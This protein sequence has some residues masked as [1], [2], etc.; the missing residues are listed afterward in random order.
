[1]V[2]G[3]L[4]LKDGVSL[5]YEQASKV[6]VTVT[7]TDSASHQITKTFSISVG[8]VNEAQTAMTLS[9]SKVTEN[10][11]GAVI[12]TLKVTDPDAGDKQSF[13]VSD[14]ALR[15]G[16]QQAPAEGRASRSTTSRARASM[17]T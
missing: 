5:N 1:M 10:A 16:Q 12:G 3:Q 2:N 15:G 17:S 7:A 4:K 9:A 13:T 6:S 8:N 14:T 11:A